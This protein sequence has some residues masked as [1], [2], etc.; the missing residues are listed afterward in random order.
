[1]ADDKTNAQQQPPTPNP[2]LKSLDR[3]VGTYIKEVVWE[4]FF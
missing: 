3:L 2:D 4:K 1:M